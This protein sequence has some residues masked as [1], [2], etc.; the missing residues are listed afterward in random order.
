[1]AHENKREMR[2][3]FFCA[4]H[5]RSSTL[6]RRCLTLS[7]P[8][9]DRSEAWGCVMPQSRHFIPPRITCIPLT[10]QRIPSTLQCIPSIHQ[11]IPSIPQCIQS[12][13]QCIPSTL[14][15]SQQQTI[16]SIS[17]KTL[18]G[19]ADTIKTNSLITWTQRLFYPNINAQSISLAFSSRW[20]RPNLTYIHININSLF[21]ETLP[22]HPILYRVSNQYIIDPTSSHPIS[23]HPKTNPIQH[24]IIRSHPLTPSHTIPFYLTSPHCHPISQRQ[25]PYLDRPPQLTSTDPAPLLELLSVAPSSSQKTRPRSPCRLPALPPRQTPPPPRPPR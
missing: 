11:C 4:C 2:A 13:L 14:C 17:S 12:I 6:R 23:S 5:R 21:P 22:R 3:C 25:S 19:R 20:N 7:H 24:N 8:A 18:P 1:M 10:L 15:L 9:E 16:S